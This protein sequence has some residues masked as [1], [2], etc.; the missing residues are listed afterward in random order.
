LKEIEIRIINATR[1]RLSSG[2]ATEG[3]VEYNNLVNELK[4]TVP[5]NLMKF[6]VI[7]FGGYST[8]LTTKFKLFGMF[9][10]QMIR[11]FINHEYEFM[12]TIS[13]AKTQLLN[14]ERCFWLWISSG[15]SIETSLR[16]YNNRVSEIMM[17]RD[18]GLRNS[19]QAQAMALFPIKINLVTDLTESMDIEDGSD[20]WK[21][22]SVD[23]IPTFDCD[24][25]FDNKSTDIK[26]TFD[27]GHSFC[28][29]CVQTTFEICKYNTIYRSAD[30][31]SSIAV[32]L[33]LLGVFV[34]FSLFLNIGIALLIGEYLGQFY[35]GF[36]IM[37]VF[38]L[39]VGFIFILFQ[40]VLIKNP[41]CN[42][43][44]K[45]ILNKNNDEQN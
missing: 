25:C 45:K 1:Y 19:T 39:I 32:R 35:Y 20:T 43:M 10:F 24:I 9:I 28:G 36:F 44:I 14:A 27:C 26:V 29:V 40:Q 31:F 18:E 17:E 13:R 15:N 4:D 12:E 2:S 41:V 7:K 8:T 6:A 37:A 38:Y 30:L 16:M 22:S 33:V 42:F 34:L 3:G 11:R 5:K 23:I 21:Q